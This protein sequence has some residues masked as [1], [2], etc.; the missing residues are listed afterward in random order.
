MADREFKI[1]D[2]H[3]ITDNEINNSK[4]FKKLKHKYNDAVKPLYKTQIYER[5]NKKLFISVFL[6][7]IIVSLIILTHSNTTKSVIKPKYEIKN[8]EKRL[9]K[10]VSF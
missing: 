10:N 8:I 7:I 1:A 4:D 6:I 2:D 9:T 5:K 3:K